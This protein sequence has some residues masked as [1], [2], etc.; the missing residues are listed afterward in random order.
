MKMGKSAVQIRTD[1]FLVRTDGL[2]ISDKD[3]AI[4]QSS[5]ELL[6]RLQW[7]VEKL[8]E[9]GQHN[10]YTLGMCRSITDCEEVITKATVGTV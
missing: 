1:Y 9:L 6:S 3:R 4:L 8:R 5:S 7:A 10:E 2:D